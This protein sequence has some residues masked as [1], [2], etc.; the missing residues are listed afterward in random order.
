MRSISSSPVYTCHLCF[1]LHGYL[2]SVKCFSSAKRCNTSEIFFFLFSG[3]IKLGT[4]HHTAEFDGYYKYSLFVSSIPFLVRC[5]KLEHCGRYLSIPIL[6]TWFSKHTGER[7]PP[8]ITVLY[9]HTAYQRVSQS[10]GQ[11]QERHTGHVTC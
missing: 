6:T 3:A 1:I 10:L 9:N 5:E 2:A 4:C 11:L 7:T 8:T